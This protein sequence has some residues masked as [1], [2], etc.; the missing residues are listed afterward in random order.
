MSDELINNQTRDWDND[1]KGLD[2]GK[3]GAGAEKAHIRLFEAQAVTRGPG[4]MNRRLKEK[5]RS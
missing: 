3:V 2:N 1:R 5:L 4:Y